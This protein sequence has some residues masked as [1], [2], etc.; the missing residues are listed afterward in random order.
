MPETEREGEGEMMNSH[1]PTRDGLIG[2]ISLKWQSPRGASEEE[3]TAAAV[4]FAID[5]GL[6]ILLILMLVKVA[7]S[8]V[9]RTIAN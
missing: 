3:A 9:A 2:M 6:C 4:I 8:R 7:V 5:W 1:F